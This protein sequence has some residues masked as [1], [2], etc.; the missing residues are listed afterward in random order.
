MTYVGLDLLRRTV[1]LKAA[2]PTGTFEFC[3]NDSKAVS[4]D[5]NLVIATYLDYHSNLIVIFFEN[6]ICGGLFIKL[7]A[8]RQM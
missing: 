5:G 7:F 6:K 2:R 3:C 4:S 1:K 8:D